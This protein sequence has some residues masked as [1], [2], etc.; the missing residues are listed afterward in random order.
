MAR[1]GD[2]EIQLPWWLALGLA[3]GAYWWFTRSSTPAPA[4]YPY[5]A[6]SGLPDEEPCSPGHYGS[7]AVN[8]A[9]R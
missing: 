1:K 4:P 5:G 6:L 3:G 8:R 2:V 9:L 7:A